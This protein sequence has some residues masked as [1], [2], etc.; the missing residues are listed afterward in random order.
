MIPTALVALA[1]FIED[2]WDEGNI[3]LI[4]DTDRDLPELVYDPS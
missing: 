1:R 4:Q 3:T 2:E